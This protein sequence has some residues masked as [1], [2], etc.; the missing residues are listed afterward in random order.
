MDSG[1][2]LRGGVVWVKEVERAATW[3][4]RVRGLLGRNGLGPDAALLIE[5]CGAVH[6]VGMRFALDLVFVD[7]QWRVTRVARNIRPGRLVVW[8]GWRAVR[9]LEIEAGRID[10]AGLAPGDPLEFC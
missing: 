3:P 2:I 8:G 4:E 10:L 6:T 1:Q 5:R 9:V 7:R